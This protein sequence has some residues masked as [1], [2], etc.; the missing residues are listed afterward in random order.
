VLRDLPLGPSDAAPTPPDAGGSDGAG[1][2]SA[3]PVD[4]SVGDASGVFAGQD[5]TCAL[6]G[7]LAYCWGDNTEGEL[8]TGGG[9][10][11]VP[12]RVDSASGFSVLASGE[13]HACGLEYATGR[14]LCWGASGSGQLG[15]GDTL[16]HPTPQPVALAASAVSLTVGYNHTC[17]ILDDASLW[18]WGDN[19]EGEIGLSDSYGA[20]NVLSPQRVSPGTRWM[21][22]SGGQG[23]TCAVQSPGTMWCWGRNTS[24]ELGLGPGQPIQ[25]RT[26]TQVGTFDDWTSVDLGQD[27]A[28]GL[29]RDGSLWCWGAGGSGELAAPPGTFQSPT[30]VGTDQ[31][32]LSVSTDIFSTCAIKKAGTLFCWGRNAEGQLGTGDTTDRTTPTLTGGAGATFAAASVGRLHACAETTDHIVQ[33]TGID[34]TGELGLG[35]TARR[36]TFTAVSLPAP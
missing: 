7:G 32:W 19:F 36:N 5:F 24:A 8:G 13:S 16:S 3:P 29:R 27:N 30:Q 33:C 20:P 17:A 23:H 1:D 2:D 22:V 25:I 9:S 14:V 28:C 11:L 34:D 6:S 4:G 10:Q 21:A 12:A 18:C 35:D 31:D 26:P 15:L